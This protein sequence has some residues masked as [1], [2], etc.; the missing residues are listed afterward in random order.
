VWLLIPL[1]IVTSWVPTLGGGKA[2]PLRIQF[3]HGHTAATLRG[4]L[5]RDEQTE[6]VLAARQGQ[7]LTVRITSMP[8]QS[9]TFT[10]QDPD[11]EEVK[12]QVEADPHTSGILPKTG[13]YSISVGRPPNQQFGTSTYV[14]TVTVQ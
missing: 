14:L 5:H 13:D 4:T 12:F 7:R 3:K 9:V 1:L 11:G 6:Y 8:R 2:M 10:L